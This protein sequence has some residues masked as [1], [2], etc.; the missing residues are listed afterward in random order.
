MKI[1]C[2]CGHI[3]SVDDPKKPYV[4]CHKCY[5][6]ISATRMVPDEFELPTESPVEPERASIFTKAKNFTKAVIK[7]TYNGLG[8]TSKEEQDK[9]L[10]I[11]KSCPLLVAN[12]PMPE[13][14]KCGCPVEQ[15]V[16]WPLEECP[17]G[18]WGKEKP[19][20]RTRSTGCSSCQK[21]KK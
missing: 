7:H 6:M 18:K 2:E 3:Q 1:I 5:S 19:Q 8:H 15:K 12:L 14:G 11:C 16:K 17:E 21:G 20:K 13:C 4:R 9:R 10:D